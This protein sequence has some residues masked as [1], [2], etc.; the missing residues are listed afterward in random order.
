MSEI[1]KDL[2]EY[3]QKERDMIIDERRD[4]LMKMFSKHV[5]KTDSPILLTKKDVVKI[6]SGAKAQFS[7]LPLPAYVEGGQLEEGDLT[8]YCVMLAFIQILNEKGAL[9]K[10]PLFNK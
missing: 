8:T 2:F 3:F 5:L 9:R 7:S 1:E 4:Y 6:V 10:M